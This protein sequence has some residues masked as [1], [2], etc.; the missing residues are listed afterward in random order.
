LHPNMRSR[1]LRGEIRDTGACVFPCFVRL[2]SN[3]P[4]G[5]A[6]IHGL[7]EV[8]EPWGVSLGVPR[9]L[10]V[11]SGFGPFRLCFACASLV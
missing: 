4:R 3:R 7:G 10:G 9:E 8:R 5:G 11:G 6:E 1:A 2:M